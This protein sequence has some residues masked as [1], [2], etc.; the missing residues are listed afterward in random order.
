MGQHRIVVSAE[1][2]AY[3]GWQC[4]LF[5]YS[6]VT[7]T[8]FQPLFV[9]HAL[10]GGW[11]TDFH[12]LVKA[13]A[14][15][16]SAPSYIRTPYDDYV[17]RN[18]AGTLLHAAE[19]CDPD[20]LI[21]LC[22]PDMIFVRS[23]VFPQ[24]LSGDYYSYLDYDRPPVRSAARRLSIA[25][26]AIFERHDTLCCGVPYVIPVQQAPALA[27]AW[28]AAVDAFPP[29]QWEDIMFAFGLACV[30]LGLPITLTRIMEQDHVPEAPLSAEMIHYCIGNALWDKRNFF[31]EAEAPRVW[32][33]AVSAEHDTILGE[34]LKQIEEAREFFGGAAL[35]AVIGRRAAG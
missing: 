8:S 19:Y 2:N 34:V 17:P 11:H 31:R 18:T 16:R 4:K 24:C 9:V 12:E 13:G 23:P 1:N 22:D 10:G 6:C 27:R 5:Y 26:E 30:G 32:H 15:V 7:R 25:W 28:L 29:R 14:L 33:P 3:I 20:D 35:P 21:L